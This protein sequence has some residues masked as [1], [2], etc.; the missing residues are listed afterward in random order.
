MLINL[1]IDIEIQM[2][3]IPNF[4]IINLSLDNY[5]FHSLKEALGGVTQ[6]NIDEGY[7][8]ASETSCFKYCNKL[9]LV[10]DGLF[11]SD[12]IFLIKK[13]LI[14][15]KTT[16]V[17]IASKEVINL[18]SIFLSYLTKRITW[19]NKKRTKNEILMNIL[20]MDGIKGADCSLAYKKL[21]CNEVNV[22]KFYVY[23]LS[24]NEISNLLGLS[25]KTISCYKAKVLKAL[26]VKSISG[27][28]SFT[29]LGEL[30]TLFSSYH[31]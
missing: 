4:K 17:V 10:I 20:T 27:L 1:L 16:V 22:F 8:N 15:R 24:Y 29:T 19:I 5:Y 13:N 3:K 26:E 12:G 28:L 21:S 14:D 25:Y 11:L 6:S 31:L 2:I 30:K 9:V 18:L 7:D 23:G